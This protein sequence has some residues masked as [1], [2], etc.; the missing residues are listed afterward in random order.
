MCTLNMDTCHYESVYLTHLVLL[1]CL[2]PTFLN[3]QGFRLAGG[4]KKTKYRGTYAQFFCRAGLF[5][6]GGGGGGGERGGVNKF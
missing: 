6:W 2:C 4:K 1:F 5:F 3:S